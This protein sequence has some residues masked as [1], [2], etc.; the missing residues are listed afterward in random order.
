VF[1]LGQSNTVSA[2]TSLSGTTAGAQLAVTNNSTASGAGG[3]KVTTPNSVAPFAV[4]SK[5]RNANL[6]ADM[7][8]GLHANG[9][10]R[11][12]QTDGTR[13]VSAGVN[14]VDQ[15]T[16]TVN[17][18]AKGFVYLDA[19]VLGESIFPSPACTDCY[20]SA[21][22]RDNSTG[23]F[24][25]AVMGHIT[26]RTAETMNVTWVFPA[27]SGTHTY[28][29][30]AGFVDLTYS[31]RQAAFAN[32]QIAA[33]FVPFGYNGGTADLEPAARADGARSATTTR[34]GVTAT[35]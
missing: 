20:L 6:N 19:S 24:S 12:A 30:Q 7:V 18:P 35:G 27:T 5:V 15:T 23:A 10:A 1:N 34:N 32:D 25:R 9:L 4:T 2:T 21:R 31:G 11:T 3:L 17:A 16:V 22:L 14:W 29:L 33:L 8:D 28:T 13:T 26:L